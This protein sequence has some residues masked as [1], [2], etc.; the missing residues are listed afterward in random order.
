MISVTREGEEL[1]ISGLTKEH[2]ELI[3]SLLAGAEQTFQ[4]SSKMSFIDFKN[5]YGQYLQMNDLQLMTEHRKMSERAVLTKEILTAL[6][7]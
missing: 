7:K 6:K 3:Q 1:A 4:G 5:S 2:E